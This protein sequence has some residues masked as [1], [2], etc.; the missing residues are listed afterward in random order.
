MLINLAAERNNNASNLVQAIVQPAFR[1][2]I[3]ST[4][5]STNQEQS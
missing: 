3:N 1:E 5:T 2:A 4:L